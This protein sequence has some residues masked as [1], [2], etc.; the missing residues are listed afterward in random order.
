MTSNEQPQEKY[1][2]ILSGDVF[3]GVSYEDAV[4]ALKKLFSISTPKAIE[5][6][7]GNPVELKKHYDLEQAR[8]IQESILDCGVNCS[9]QKVTE[10]D[11]G[12]SNEDHLSTSSQREAVAEDESHYQVRVDDAVDRSQPVSEPEKRSEYSP[13]DEPYDK[14]EVHST[15]ADGDQYDDREARSDTKHDGDF[16]AVEVFIGPNSRYY[17]NRFS[18]LRGAGARLLSLFSWHWPAFICFY[19]WAMYRK[20]WKWAAINFA[21]WLLLV[22]NASSILVYGI[23]IIFW[24]GLA[25]FLYWR[26]VRTYASNFSSS[27]EDDPAPTLADGLQPFG[28]DDLERVGGV[29]RLGLIFGFLFSLFLFSQMMNQVG[30]VFMERYGDEI[31]DVLP[32]SGSLTRGD[33][34]VIDSISQSEEALSKTA[35]TLGVLATSIKLYMISAQKSS[36][37]SMVSQFVSKLSGQSMKDGWGKIVKFHDN[38]DHFMIISSGPDGEFFNNDDVRQRVNWVVDNAPD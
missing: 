29:S 7:K 20:L 9:I 35:S 27:N 25:N 3:A 8:S 33:G 1:K 18:Q 12:E 4:I 26:R 11:P 30:M 21:G 36:D 6:V 16:D 5:L 22:A 24:T 15:E 32:G 17:L 28:R 13:Q 23:W 10:L 34:M 38:G 19:H 2:I 31:S 37:P 14:E